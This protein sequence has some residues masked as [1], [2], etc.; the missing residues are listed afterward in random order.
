MRVTYQSIIV[1]SLFRGDNLPPVIPY[2][3]LVTSC[4]ICKSC[5]KRWFAER[6]GDGVGSTRLTQQCHNVTVQDEI[7]TVGYS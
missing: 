7:F 1:Y 6:T 2:F 5:L 4:G 3:S